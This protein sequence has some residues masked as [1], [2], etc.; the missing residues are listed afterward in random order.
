MPAS[1]IGYF[2]QVLCSCSDVVAVAS[3]VQNPKNWEYPEIAT[4]AEEG[5]VYDVAGQNWSNGLL[6]TTPLESVGRFSQ[7]ASLA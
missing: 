6:H 5:R 1:E 7:G 4:G 2:L 3:P